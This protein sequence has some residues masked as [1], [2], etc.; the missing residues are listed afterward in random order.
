MVGLAYKSLCNVLSPMS[1]FIDYRLNTVYTDLYLSC[2]FSG[3]MISV[4]PEPK[5][6]K[7]N[8]K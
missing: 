1:D 6:G 3:A 7:T 4:C 8:F 2:S 5:A